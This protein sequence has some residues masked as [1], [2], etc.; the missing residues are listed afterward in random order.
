[1]RT[2]ELTVY[3]TLLLLILLFLGRAHDRIVIN[4]LCDNPEGRGF[5]TQW[6][7]WILSIYLNL[8]A[9][10]GPGIY[11]ACNRNEYQK[12]KRKILFGSRAWPVHEADNLRTIFG[13]IV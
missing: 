11:S 13:P 5:E 8:P 12:Q 6:D 2:L 10:L 7:S 4:A 3:L 9:T 1:M